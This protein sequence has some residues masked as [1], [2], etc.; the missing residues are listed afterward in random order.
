MDIKVKVLPF[1]TAMLTYTLMWQQDRDFSQMVTNTT[2]RHFSPIFLERH[3]LLLDNALNN[4]QFYDHFC[5][6][7][8]LT[9]LWFL[10]HDCF[11]SQ[12]LEQLSG[13]VNPF[14]PGHKNT[15]TGGNN[16]KYKFFL[17]FF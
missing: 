1:A 2:R 9:R 16:Q 8:I 12:C 17:S 13:I 15:I 7:N 10:M 5:H 6:V 3:S 11:I 14:P 4:N